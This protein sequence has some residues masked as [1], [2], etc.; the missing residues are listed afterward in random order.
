M[1][2]QTATHAARGRA[3]AMAR[4]QAVTQNGGAASTPY[5]QQGSPS[6]P[7]PAQAGASTDTRDLR[8]RDLARARRAALANG[9]KNGPTPAASS[10]PPTYSPPPVATARSAP[11]NPVTEAAPIAT[12]SPAAAPGAPLRGRDLARARRASMAKGGRNGSGNG[13][14]INNGSGNGNGQGSH[15]TASNRSAAA[16][17]S[18]PASETSAASSSHAAPPSVAPVRAAVAS[19]NL[20]NLRG[21]DLAQARRAL[22][23]RGGTASGVAGNGGRTR[24]TRQRPQPATGSP[25][26]SAASAP[27]R[28]NE[29]APMNTSEPESVDNDQV[30]NDLDGLCEIAEQTPALL[31]ADANSV[32][33]WCRDRRSAMA[34]R[35][36][37]AL[38]GSSQKSSRPAHSV[39]RNG[40]N[41]PKGRDAARQHR[42]ELCRNGRGDSPSC[43]PTGRVRPTPSVAPPKV[44]AGTTLSGQKVTGTQVERKSKVTGN[45]PGTCRSVT[46]TEYIGS[47]QFSDF[48]P[49]LPEPNVAKVGVS[50]TGSGRTLT[51]TS[52]G[53]SERVTGDEAGSCKPVTGTEYLGSERFEQFCAAKGLMARPAKVITGVTQRKS[54]PVTGADEARSA[55]VTGTEPGSARAITGSQY[56][57]AGAARLTING[58]SKVA[59]THTVAGRPI[60]GT[61]VGRS[62][63]VTGDE[64]GSCRL[65]SGTEY[66]SNEQFATICNTRPEPAPAKVGIDE[67][68]QGQ[69]I[70]GNLVDR[71]EKVT[72]NEPGSCLRVTGSQY[73]EGKLCGGGTDKVQ[74]MST[75]SG[76]P[77]TGTRVGHGPKLTG[78]EHGGCEPVT[79]TQYYGE[80]Q[81]AEYCVSTPEPPASKVIVSQSNRGLPVSGTPLGRSGNVTGDEPGSDLEIS[82]TPYAGREQIQ[83]RTRVAELP[84]ATLRPVPLR[85]PEP[86]T[87]I[88]RYQAPVGEPLPYREPAAVAPAPA[89]LD[90]SIV[91]PARQAQHT[92]SR[93]TGSAFGGGGR[94]TGPVN[95]AAGLVSG[96]PEFRYRDDELDPL[97]MPMAGLAPVGYPELQQPMP[98]H[99]AAPALGAAPEMAPASAPG[100]T[101]MMAPSPAL[102][103]VE[104]EPGPTRITGEGRDDGPRITGDDWARGNRIT[105]TEGRWAQSRNPTQ[106]GNP[107]AGAPGMASGARGNRELDRPEVPPARVTGSAGNYG[108]GPTVTL[109]GGARG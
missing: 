80:E 62:V 43:R 60:S 65:I 97:P 35:G 81:F 103:V 90:F 104:G 1:P 47:E 3:A 83:R 108:R 19:G 102:P 18:A 28:V 40:Q 96:T 86:P 42:Q 52:V 21:R 67:S 98:A 73:G 58:P 23:A 70:T 84:P 4:R 54:L 53:R 10:T 78:D 46:G 89:A 31:G 93:I 24:P 25:V 88:P 64:A 105:G 76:Q 57:D 48:C 101:T 15:V 100:P 56:A 39:R 59:L 94:V 99:G 69:R 92:R 85:T 41:G 79:G 38:P 49:T 82:G 34:N 61:E 9:G 45:E 6:R 107:R 37:R 75:L 16:T 91:S 77:L 8:G 14:G 51:G 71:S 66:L 17:S 30:D 106:R 5:R 7:V 55:A 26:Q 72:G 74:S 44:E 36:K 50:V 63:R 109:S 22:L 87:A 27:K 20:N 29:P 12:P 32:R 68:R 13:N 33:K 11:A 2:E 95:M